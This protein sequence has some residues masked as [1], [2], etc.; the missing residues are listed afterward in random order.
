MPYANL[1]VQSFCR[2]TR[3]VL[4][5]HASGLTH[6]DA[7]ALRDRLKA[8][9]AANEDAVGYG[10]VT[11]PL[12]EQARP[13]PAARLAN[14]ARAYVMREAHTLART[15]DEGTPYPARL[16]AALRAVALR[17]RRCRVS[18]LRKQADELV[19]V[20]AETGAR[21]DYA[22]KAAEALRFSLERDTR[23]LAVPSKLVGVKAY[24]DAAGALASRLA[25]SGSTRGGCV[26]CETDG[27]SVF[28]L[29]LRLGA[30]QTKHAA[31]LASLGSGPYGAVRVAVIA[32]TGG[33]AIVTKDGQA[34]RTLRGVN[35]AF[36]AGPALGARL[37]QRRSDRTQAAIRAGRLVEA[38]PGIFVKPAAAVRIAEQVKRAGGHSVAWGRLD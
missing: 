17:P 35:V 23:G 22:R 28:G 24:Q 8:D 5:V 19:R 20:C 29:G 1:A 16:G 7:C 6:A 26:V 4:A 21:F 3:R 38:G 9:D 11:I 25:A 30:V 27:A 12:A 15:G 2:R 32:V 14:V 10:L 36:E 13:T 33:Q 34:V 31:W 18:I 37:Q